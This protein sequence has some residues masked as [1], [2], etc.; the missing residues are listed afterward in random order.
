MKEL[1]KIVS[2]HLGKAG[3]GT[4]VAPYITPDK[5][6]PGLLVPVPRVLNRTEYQIDED[7]LPFVGYDAWNCLLA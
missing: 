1:D 4:I 2:K 3:D 6:D 5:A 7:D